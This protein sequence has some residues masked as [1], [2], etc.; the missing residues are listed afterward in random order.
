MNSAHHPGLRDGDFPTGFL[1]SLHQPHSV[2]GWPR[3][4]SLPA[5]GWHANAPGWTGIPLCHGLCPVGRCALPQ[6]TPPACWAQAAAACAPSQL[7]DSG[8]LQAPP[9]LAGLCPCG[10]SIAPLVSTCKALS[11]GNCPSYFPHDLQERR[12][13]VLATLCAQVKADQGEAPQKEGVCVCVCM[14][15]QVLTCVPRVYVPTVCVC[16]VPVYTHMPLCVC[17]CKPL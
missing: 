3:G 12:Q 2:P 11:G 4:Q 6:A 10:I 5:G 16:I 7:P 1:L 15:V 9:R 14:C 13:L 8:S 17:L